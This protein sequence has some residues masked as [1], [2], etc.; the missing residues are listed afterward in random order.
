[1]SAGTEDENRAQ[2]EEEQKAHAERKKQ[3]I[4][5]TELLMDRVNYARGLYQG[6]T[7]KYVRGASIG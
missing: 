1:M 5:I 7:E 2:A 3:L 6:T 4:A